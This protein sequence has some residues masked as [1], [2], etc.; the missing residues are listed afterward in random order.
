MKKLLLG[1]TISL[2]LLLVNPIAFIS[3][4]APGVTI[5]VPDNFPTIQ[6]AI[7][8]AVSGD[9]VLVR[10]GVYKLTAALDFNGKA[11][12]VISQNGASNCFLDGQLQTRVLY[13]HSGEGSSSVLSGFTIQNGGNVNDG[14][15]IYCVASSPTISA[16][17]ISAN[18]ARAANIWYSI[19]RG[20]GI[21]CDASSPSI[22]KCNI[23]GNYVDAPAY[24]SDVYGAGIYTKGGA[25]IITDCTLSGNVLIATQ[26]A[27]GGGIYS[28]GSS[29]SII[30]STFSNNSVSTL[31][32]G[33]WAKGGGLHFANSTPS[34]VNCIISGNSAQGG[35]GIYFDQSS[36]FSSLT[37]CTIVRNTASVNG[38][39]L[40]CANTSPKIINSILWEDSPQE[41]FN[42]GTSSPTITYSDVLGGNTGTGNI[43]AS[44]LFIDIAAQNFH[45]KSASPCINVGDNAAPYLPT[46]DKDGQPR[47]WNG[48][49]DM[50]AYEYHPSPIQRDFNGDG[51]SDILWRNTA[52]GDINVWFM[53]GA[54]ITG[55]T[56]LPRVT[57]Q[58]WQIVGI[59]DFNG[60]GSADLLWR[61][62]PSG[63]MNLWF[64]NGG[65]V[66]GDAWL[67]RVSDPQWQVAGIGDFNKDGKSD[68]VW[69]HTVSGD[70]D[71]WFVNGGIVTGDAWLPRVTDQQW[72]IAGVG[73]FNGD[74]GGDIVWRYLPSGDIDVWLMNGTTVTSDAWLP[75]VSNPQWQI[76]AIADI[77][78]DGTSDI[79]WRHTV[80]GDINVWFLNG[81]LFA[82]D[83]WLPKVADQQWKIFGPR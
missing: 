42:E 21:Y 34:L 8:A 73:D 57:D 39:G 22:T 60:D 24:Y 3:F 65:I 69:R 7:D 41:V 18:H 83:G 78:G 6:Q 27:L 47:I 67:P 68:V 38:G 80:S 40:Y 37:N 35:A 16:C 75:R 19:A 59:G 50:G 61:Y 14:A 46:T 63:D 23:T 70:I 81:V 64:V 9:T 43:N 2:F 5:I 58:Q 17:T 29:P 53:N 48:T 56:W 82:S 33:Y 25:P 15:G 52:S 4:G 28:S 26:F 44:P 31:S 36:A 1:L 55:D 66:T 79:I 54:T 51:K 30:N 20:G 76:N 77:N 11:I 62:T 10:D 71:V 49:V 13:F 12:S 72:Q 32:S 74:G 45:L